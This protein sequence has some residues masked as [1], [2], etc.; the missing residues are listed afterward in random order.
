MDDF[1]KPKLISAKNTQPCTTLQK[2]K[3]KR[4]KS[5]IYT[6]WTGWISP[7][8]EDYCGNFYLMSVLF[9]FVHLFSSPVTFYDISSDFWYCEIF[10]SSQIGDNSKGYPLEIF[11]NDHSVFE[12]LFQV[13]NCDGKTILKK[14]SKLT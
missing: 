10:F 12:K 7:I 1:G 4:G 14:S 8:L 13:S 3:V 11:E 2:I 9:F 5:S 6:V